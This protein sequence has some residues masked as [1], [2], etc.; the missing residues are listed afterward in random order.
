MIFLIPM[1]LLVFF[2][3]MNSETIKASYIIITIITIIIIIIIII[4]IE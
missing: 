1:N 3:N 2:W 4:I